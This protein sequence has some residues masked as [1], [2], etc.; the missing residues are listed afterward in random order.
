[1]TASH[2]VIGAS[3]LE[4]YRELDAVTD[5]VRH[6]HERWDGGGYPDGLRG[7]SISPPAR[8]YAAV[9]R[10]HWLIAGEPRSA[11]MSSADAL[12]QMRREAGGALA[13]DAVAAIAQAVQEE[14][15]A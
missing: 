1:M 11:R 12:A 8:L 6:H 10:Y 14:A 9:D 3:L 4:P 15:A 2:P 5:I 13:P 7:E